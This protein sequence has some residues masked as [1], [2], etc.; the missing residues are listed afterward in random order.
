[1]AQD[2]DSRLRY[3]IEHELERL[4]RGARIRL[5][6]FFQVVARTMGVLR[7]VDLRRG[8]GSIRAMKVLLQKIDEISLKE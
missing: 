8:S 1:M 3:L 6:L 2:H 7:N 5:V 4:V